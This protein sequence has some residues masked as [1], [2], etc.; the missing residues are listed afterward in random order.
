[1]AEQPRSAPAPVDSLEMEALEAMATPGA[2]AAAPPS[3]EGLG[4]R[5]GRARRGQAK[6]RRPPQPASAGGWGGG[7]SAGVAEPDPSG[8][9][10][11]LPAPEV[12]VVPDPPRSRVSRAPREGG[13]EGR[14]R[15]E[16]RRRGPPARA[17]AGE[18]GD[19][20]RP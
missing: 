16:A 8:T 7:G 1:M 11:S 6:P 12:E 9:H 20:G 10:C 15:D 13:R 3:G 2:G 4:R 17:G 18:G 5:D 19:N 14:R